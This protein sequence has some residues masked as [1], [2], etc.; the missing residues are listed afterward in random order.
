MAD[1]KLSWTELRRAL[2]TR[3]GI[4]EKEANSFLNAFSLPVAPER[5]H[6]VQCGSFHKRQPG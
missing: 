6:S 4:S 1:N 3:A 5:R 2:M